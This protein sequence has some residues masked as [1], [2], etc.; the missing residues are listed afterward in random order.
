MLSFSSY[1]SLL[2]ILLIPLWFFLK[3]MGILTSHSFPLLFTEDT[4]K[5]FDGNTKSFKFFS[6][7]STILFCL[8]FIFVVMFALEICIEAAGEE[9]FTAFLMQES[10]FQPVVAAVVG[11]IPN[12]AASVALASLASAGVISVGEMLAG[13]FAGAG[14]GVFVLFKMNK[15][16]RENILV[17]LAVLVIGV[18]FGFVA[19][20]IPAFTL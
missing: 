1:S 12:C 4:K 18:I 13:L 20:L 6:V 15:H 9:A 3:K 16:P 19:D 17:V 10:L 7:V 14:I 5:F 2:L 8:A 11:L